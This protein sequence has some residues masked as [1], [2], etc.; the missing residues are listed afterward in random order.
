MV[1]PAGKWYS[2]RI[3]LKSNVELRLDE[4]AVIEFSGEVDDYQ[5]AVFTRHE[6]SRLW[7]PVRLYMPTAQRT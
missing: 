7:V 4:G 5:P 3:E 6:A 1:V 2:G